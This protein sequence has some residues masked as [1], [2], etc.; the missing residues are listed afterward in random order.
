MSSIET[1]SGTKPISTSRF[2][3]VPAEQLGDRARR[4]DQ[5]QEGEDARLDRER[6]ERDLLV[7]EHAGDADHAAVEDREGE[8]RAGDGGGGCG[9][10]CVMALT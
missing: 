6:P 5:H 2:A 4:D 3:V 8:E 9:L 7:A 10:L 1:I